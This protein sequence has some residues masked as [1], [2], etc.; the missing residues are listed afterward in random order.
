MGL[1]SLGGASTVV[2]TQAAWPEAGRAAVLPSNGVLSQ[3]ARTAVPRRAA[4]Q[5]V[6][7]RVVVSWRSPCSH[8]LL[9]KLTGPGM[10]LRAVN[11]RTADD[12]VG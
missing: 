8:S 3:V 4:M 5:A 7:A 9:C 11:L 6:E 2:S 10:R 1:P 12:G